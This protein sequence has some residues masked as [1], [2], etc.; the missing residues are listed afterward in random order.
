MQA[1]LQAAI[2]MFLLAHYNFEYIDINIRQSDLKKY[3]LAI[4]ISWCGSGQTFFTG[5]LCSERKVSDL[6]FTG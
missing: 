6:L 2:V 5:C 4:R 1:N 3:Y